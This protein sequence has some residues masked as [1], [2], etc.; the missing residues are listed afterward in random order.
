MGPARQLRHSANP[1]ALRVRRVTPPV[2]GTTRDGA[3]AP[4][5]LRLSSPRRGYRAPGEARP[6]GRHAFPIVDAASATPGPGWAPDC[7]VRQCWQQ[8]GRIEAGAPRAR[9]GTGIQAGRGGFRVRLRFRFR[10][11]EADTLPKALPQGHSPAQAPPN[12][13]V[14]SPDC[15]SSS[16]LLPVHGVV[17]RAVPHFGVLFSTSPLVHGISK[18]ARVALPREAFLATPTS[19]GILSRALLSTCCSH[20]ASFVKSRSYPHNKMGNNNR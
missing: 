2:S 10:V 7:G 13:P 11:R 1:R 3:S 14:F 12:I 16:T 18:R 20:C 4:E 17:F 19:T 8:G 5:P 9:P 15:P 6:N